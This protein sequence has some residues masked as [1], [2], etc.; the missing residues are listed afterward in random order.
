ML[1]HLS[2]AAIHLNVALVEAEE[3][4]ELYSAPTRQAI[5]DLLDQ[6]NGLDRQIEN[7]EEPFIPP[8]LITYPS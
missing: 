4:P 8:S 6:I 1:H 3:H 5:S 2:A 7:E